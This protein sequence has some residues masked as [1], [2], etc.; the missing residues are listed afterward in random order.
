[1]ALSGIN[2]L[3]T[4]NFLNEDIFYNKPITFLSCKND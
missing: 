2:N 3:K 1:M 4:F